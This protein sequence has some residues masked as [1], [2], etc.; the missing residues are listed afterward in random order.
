MTLSKTCNPIF[1]YFLFGLSEF[2]KKTLLEYLRNIISHCI[3]VVRLYGLVNLSLKNS[4]VIK[5]ALNSEV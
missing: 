4:E 1:C 2:S 3:K 5:K